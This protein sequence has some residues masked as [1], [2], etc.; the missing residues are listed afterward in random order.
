MTMV[1][2]LDFGLQVTHIY[3][4]RAM[5]QN[6]RFSLSS[7]NSVHSPTQEEQCPLFLFYMFGPLVLS[8]DS[9]GLGQGEEE[10]SI[11]KINFKKQ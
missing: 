2:A 8:G 9:V 11:E 7:S 4:M 6:H 10:V 1:T 3:Q 5:G